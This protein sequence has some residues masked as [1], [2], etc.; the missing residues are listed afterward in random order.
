MY[1]RQD[2]QARSEARYLKPTPE[3]VLWLT[4]E[5]HAQ[6]DSDLIGSAE[7][8]KEGARSLPGAE[9]P[10][11]YMKGY[12]AGFGS[13]A[14]N[15]NLA[16]VPEGA[17]LGAEVL[18]CHGDFI[19]FELPPG[20]VYIG[21]SIAADYRAGDYNY[22]ELKCISLNPFKVAIRPL[23]PVY[24]SGGAS[25]GD[26][27]AGTSSVAVIPD[28]AVK[29]LHVQ[30]PVIVTP[31]SLDLS[32]AGYEAQNL[33]LIID[34]TEAGQWVRIPN[35]TYRPSV[36]ICLRAVSFPA[37]GLQVRFS[38]ND[39]LDLPQGLD[40]QILENVQEEFRYFEL[41]KPGIYV[42]IIGSDDGGG[43]YI[44]DYRLPV[45]D[46][47]D[48]AG[49]TLSELYNAGNW[50]ANGIYTGPS[51]PG[52]QPGMIH[53]AAAQPWEYKTDGAGSWYR[54][55]RAAQSGSAVSVLDDLQDV[56]IASPQAGQVLKY[57]GTAWENAEEESAALP[58]LP[59]YASE[60]ALP[61][62]AADGSV[63][64]VQALSTGVPGLVFRDA[65]VWK[66]HSVLKFGSN[67]IRELSEGGDH[68]DLR[69]TGS[70]NYTVEV[71]ETQVA[72]S[73]STAMTNWSA[74]N[75]KTFLCNP[76]GPGLV[77]TAAPVST[78]LAGRWI[79]VVNNSASESIS[80][81]AGAGSSFPVSG[82]LALA[83]A[84]NVTLPPGGWV[85][86]ASP[87]SGTVYWVLDK[88]TY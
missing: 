42:S 60:A 81:A 5:R 8:L 58:L 79:K 13:Q 51:I 27:I 35:S 16:L 50:D 18:I 54:V 73:A 80:L 69:S 31:G 62:T 78:S 17:L 49:L 3:S 65:G 36:R 70:G 71:R 47:Y 39:D 63:A 59:V 82:K 75:G 53:S 20:A 45:Y 11:D 41:D 57:N 44:E 14:L 64:I 29:K 46:P 19:P 7:L 52:T 37:T 1:S 77:F 43:L 12:I 22:F 85:K 72:V 26:T 48:V 6:S 9:L 86:L 66:I 28:G 56:A 23:Y 15:G 61:G 87:S 21:E 67:Y 4:Y 30:H 33:L 24:P 40:L 10:F 74:D 88:G 55:A 84:S 32:P 83:S 2:L 25:G 76:S 38:I 34:A 68:I